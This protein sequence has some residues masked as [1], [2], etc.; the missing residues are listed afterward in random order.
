MLFLVCGDCVTE[1]LLPTHVCVHI[2]C[3]SAA[4]L[5]QRSSCFSCLFTWSLTLIIANKYDN[6]IF[7]YATER[8]R[9]WEG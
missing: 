8:V 2:S 9:K 7:F 5:L 1:L 3:E 4:L 6:M